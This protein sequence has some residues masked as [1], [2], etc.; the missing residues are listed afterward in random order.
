[1]AATTTTLVSVAVAV[2]AAAVTSA[3]VVVAADVACHKWSW[4]NKEMDDTASITSRGH[5]PNGLHTHSDTII[6]FQ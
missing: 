5:G 2:T 3:A 1:M 4:T 6:H